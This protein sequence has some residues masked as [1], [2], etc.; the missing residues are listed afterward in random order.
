MQEITQPMQLTGSGQNTSIEAVVAS[1]A[2]VLFVALR[3]LCWMETPLN[4]SSPVLWLEP[5]F[6]S[7]IMAL[8]HSLS[9][10]WSVSR[11]HW[12]L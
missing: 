8:S 6:Q 12:N 11:Q 10:S 1:V 7:P 3:T 4:R 9:F 5:F 2:F